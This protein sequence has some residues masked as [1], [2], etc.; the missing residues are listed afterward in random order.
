MRP[1][2]FVLLSA[3]AAPLSGDVTAQLDPAG[4]CADLILYAVS[5]DDTLLLRIDADGLIADAGGEPSSQTFTLPDA[6]VTVVLEQGSKISDAICDDVIENGGPQVDRTYTATAGTA[7]FTIRPGD[8]DENSRADLTL[9][10]LTLEDEDG[11][12]V[13]VSELVWTDVGVGWLAG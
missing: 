1:I 12:V 6:A 5:D 4:G 10:D 7:A 2:V 9:T 3:C 13:T 11:H 8:T